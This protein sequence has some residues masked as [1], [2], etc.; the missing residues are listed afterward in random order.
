MTTC[1]ANGAGA[2]GAGAKLVGELNDGVLIGEPKLGGGAKGAGV[3]GLVAA[4]NAIF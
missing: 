3:V 2:I 4:C 1:G